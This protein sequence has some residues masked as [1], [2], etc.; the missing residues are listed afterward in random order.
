MPLALV[1]LLAGMLT[2]LSPCVLPLLPVIVGGSVSGGKN[3]YT[4]YII[5]VSLALS[6]FVF[7][8]LLRLSTL[9]LEVSPQFWTYVSGGLITVFGIIF[10]FPNLWERL[11]AKI[12]FNSNANKLLGRSSQQTGVVGP[13]LMGVALGPVFSSCSPTY[14]IIIATVLPASLATGLIYL[15]FYVIG[16]SGMLLLIAIAGQ[17]AVNR[18]QWA[19]DPN[20]IFR[21]VLG[22]IFIVVGL[23][24]IT[25]FDKSIEAWLVDQGLYINITEFE[26]DLINN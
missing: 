13:I 14:A 3:K 1:S 4:P 9:F 24:I 25:G 16:L 26:F 8:L 11:S 23:G 10:L 2:I 6:V 22:A 20:G 17:K 12:N 21:K 7:T 19:S 18:L 15:L 5:T